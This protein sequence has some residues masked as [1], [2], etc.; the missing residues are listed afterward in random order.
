MLLGSQW[1]ARTE[2]TKAPLLFLTCQSLAAWGP[3]GAAPWALFFLAKIVWHLGVQIEFSQAVQI[4]Y[5]TP[6]FPVQIGLAL[7]TGWVLG[8]VFRQRY[9]LWLWVI[10]LLALSSVA[11]G[12]PL[13]IP[14]PMEWAVYPPIN[15]LTI[16]Q[17]A[18]LDFLD[19][20]KHLFGW[21]VGIQPFNQVAV[22][23]PFYSAAAYSLGAL[24]AHTVADVPRLFETMRNLR[25][26]RLILCVTVPWFCI[27]VALNWQ[28]MAVRYPAMRTWSGLLFVLEPVL[29]ISILM[30]SIFAIAVSLAGA[31]FAMTRFFLD[32]SNRG[33]GADASGP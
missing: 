7:V 17:C 31:R 2:I 1:H 30:T 15:H 19:R 4:L 20:M 28:P 27:K 24:M 23:L 22:T 25:V 13:T 16:A 14:A 8:G 32:S 33:P 12:F 5:G 26:K 11:V 9:M 6:Y 21:G 18:R 10:P 3:I 29:V